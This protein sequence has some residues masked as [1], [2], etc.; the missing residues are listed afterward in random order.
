M[1]KIDTHPLEGLIDNQLRQHDYYSY[2]GMTW[3]P[4]LVNDEEIYDAL[5]NPQKSPYFD[6]MHCEYGDF[7]TILQANATLL[8][9]M[10]YAVYSG[11]LFSLIVNDERYDNEKW[12]YYYMHKKLNG[13]IYEPIFISLLP[14]I[15]DDK[16]EISDE[17]KELYITDSRNVFS[18]VY[19]CIYSFISQTGL[20]NPN[21]FEDIDKD[22]SYYKE[23]LPDLLNKMHRKGV[24]I[25]YA[26]KQFHKR[27]DGKDLTSKNLWGD[28]NELE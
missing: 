25:F 11:Y 8:N 19:R 22:S 4:C 5:L 18:L 21:L 17:L 23:D 14:Q 20:D 9:M 16:Y 24:H 1:A 6:P 3:K 2:G 15:F 28:K 13:H 27:Q 26:G 7:K 10:F 12:S